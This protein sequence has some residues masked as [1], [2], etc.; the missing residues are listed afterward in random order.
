MKKVLAIAALLIMGA[1][2]LVAQHDLTLAPSAVG[3]SDPVAPPRAAAPVPA[4]ASYQ[5]SASMELQYS[6]L[7][8]ACELET[9]NDEA[10]R[11][12]FAFVS[13]LANNRGTSDLTREPWS[14]AEADLSELNANPEIFAVAFFAHNNQNDAALSAAIQTAFNDPRNL[15]TGSTASPGGGADLV[16]R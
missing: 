6:Q 5:P 8:T 4:A 1:S 3:V 9:D 11:Y 2:T 13:L 14:Q 12:C 15:Q 16:A 10:N 7:F